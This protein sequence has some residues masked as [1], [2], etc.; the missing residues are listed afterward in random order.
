MDLRIVNICNNN[1]L[2]C[3][4]SSYRDKMFFIPYDDI[5][6]T[7]TKTS[8]TIIN[9]YWGNSLMHPDILNIIAFCKKK[10]FLSVW[11]LSNTYWLDLEKLTLLIDNWLTSFWYYFNSFSKDNHNIVT[12]WW[13]E[14]WLLLKNISLIN[15]SWINSKCIIHINK[16]NLSRL[17]NDLLILNKKYNIQNFEF[18]N[19]FPFDKPYTNKNILEYDIWNNINNINNIFNII[20]IIK[21]NVVFIKFSKDFFWK[22]K[23]FYSYK[24]WILKQIWEEDTE[25]LKWK[26]KPFC[27]IEKRCDKCFLKDFCNLTIIN[28]NL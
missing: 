27:L 12:N 23:E 16:L 13:I 8:D 9:F 18:I 1:C 24:K 2:Y 26:E 7:I 28:R 22:Y 5:V 10:W 17:S 21:L 3:L 11:I 20:N 6:K 15:N 14:Y 19:Y 25:R 4:E